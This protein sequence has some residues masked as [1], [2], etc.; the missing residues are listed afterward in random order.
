MTD[1]FA[2]DFA[3]RL[4]GEPAPAALRSSVTSVHW[5]TAF[6][7][8]DRVELS[9]ANHDL[10][11]LDH[12]AL[13]LHTPLELTIGYAPSP[14]ERVFS[15]TIVSHSAQFPSGGAPTLSVA[16]Q[17]ARGRL[18]QGTRARGFAVEVP[19]MGLQPVPDIAVASQVVAERG[20]IPEFEPVGAALSVLLGGVELV[21]AIVDPDGSQRA[22][23][24]QE[25]ETDHEFLK[26]I[27]LENGWELLI[28]HRGPLGG[29]QLRFFSPLDHLTADVVLGW[30]RSLLD[31]SPRLS[32][33][34]DLVSVTVPVWV[35]RLKQQLNVTV[36]WDWDEASL[37]IDVRPGEGDLSVGGAAGKILVA[38]P[39]TPFTAPR[40]ILAHLLPRLHERLTAKAT[41]IGDPRIVPGAVVQVEGVGE[42]FGGLYRVTAATHTLDGSGYRTSFD[43]RKELWFGSIPRPAQGAVPIAVTSSLT[44]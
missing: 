10:R 35:A 32:T 29:S 34:G 23:R 27:A 28:D 25:A 22:I 4:A 41:T 9:L 43:V 21:G 18:Q 17:D 37:D 30:G 39:V 6:E 3:V 8:A 38:E 14:L 5:A 42:E 7:G 19:T 44:R 31:F 36:S 16:A 33:I 13:R 2:P 20:L 11:W 1:T 15:G 40:K 12:R 24:R 26:R